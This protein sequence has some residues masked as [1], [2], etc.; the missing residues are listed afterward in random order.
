MRI[1]KYTL[2]FYFF[3]NRVPSAFFLREWEGWENSFQGKG[4][5]RRSCFF[6]KKKN[7]K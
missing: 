2:I 7:V 6:L 1:K 4:P 3:L 5:K